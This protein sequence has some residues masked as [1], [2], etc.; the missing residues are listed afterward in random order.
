MDSVIMARPTYVTNLTPRFDPFRNAG[1]NRGSEPT[2]LSQTA[3][4]SYI[5]D[6]PDPVILN[7]NN[8]K[9]DSGTENF[10]EKIKIS[11][12]NNNKMSQ[13]MMEP[14]D[15]PVDLSTHD[16]S[17]VGAMD[18][19]RRAPKETKESFRPDL[20]YAGAS[21]PKPGIENKFKDPTD[22]TNFMYDRTLFAPL[23]RRYG[24]VQTDFIRGDVYVAPTRFGWF[25][26]P[27]NPGTDLNPGFFNLNYPS[28]E[29]SVAGQDTAVV[30]KNA[31]ITLAE[32][33]AIQQNNPFSTNF[34]HR[35]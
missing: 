22:P 31:G 28:V 9:N 18:N 23:K 10:S 12:N 34:L 14:I 6:N 32:L 27:S 15:A 19:D 33:E 8:P 1:V 30:R 20:S 25:D 24:A 21:L 7:R 5:H 26:V 3:M 16:F 17:R 11:S 35:P 13:F 4:G 2:Y 29:A